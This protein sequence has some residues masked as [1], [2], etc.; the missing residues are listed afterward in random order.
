MLNKKRFIDA[1]AI[2]VPKYKLGLFGL[3]KQG[4]YQ[5]KIDG[6]VEIKALAPTVDAIEVVRCND[7]KFFCNPGCPMQAD[8]FGGPCF[9]DFCSYG[10]TRDE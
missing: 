6:I 2:Q 3:F 5:G 7:C 8:D 9:D 10:E 4:Y 1:N